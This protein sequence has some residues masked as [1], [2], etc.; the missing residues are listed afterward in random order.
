MENPIGLLHDETMADTFLLYLFKMLFSASLLLVF[1]Q[2]CQTFLRLNHLK[3]H[4][5]FQIIVY[6]EWNCLHSILFLMMMVSYSLSDYLLWLHYLAY[7]TC[8]LYHKAYLGPKAWGFF[9]QEERKAWIIKIT[10]P[11]TIDL[12]LKKSKNKKRGCWY[13]NSSGKFFES[14][15]KRKEKWA[16]KFN[17]QSLF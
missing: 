16:S 3:L 8:H 14:L 1:L 4:S 15:T 5:L 7:I 13:R 11:C 6:I 17:L 12:M 9:S 10:K 2:T